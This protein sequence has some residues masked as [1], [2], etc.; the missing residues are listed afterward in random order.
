M[1]I[2]PTAFVRTCFDVET[3]LRNRQPFTDRTGTIFAQIRTAHFD[4]LPRPIPA[5]LSLK[6]RN[7]HLTSYTVYS[8]RTPIAVFSVNKKDLHAPLQLLWFNVRRYENRI[9]AHQALIRDI[10][11]SDY[12][13]AA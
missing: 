11:C 1:S 5:E 12:F 7:Q 9:A 4:N 10:A 2:K 6:L 8:Y 13:A 3:A